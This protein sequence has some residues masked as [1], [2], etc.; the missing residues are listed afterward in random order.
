MRVPDC[1]S[2]VDFFSPETYDAWLT[3]VDS[4]L[5]LVRDWPIRMA[6]SKADT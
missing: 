4:L 1:R 3:L 5:T 6:E 2:M